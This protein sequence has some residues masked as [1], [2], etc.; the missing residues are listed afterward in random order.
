MT[1]IPSLQS[2]C[3]IPS[4]KDVYKFTKAH[5]YLQRNPAAAKR[6]ID[7][8][9]VFYRHLSFYRIR[10]ISQKNENSNDSSLDILSNPSTDENMLIT[11][12]NI[13]NVIQKW[14][15]VD[16]LDIQEENTSNDSNSFIVIFKTAISAHVMTKLIKFPELIQKNITLTIEAIDPIPEDAR[17][18]LVYIQG[19]GPD[20][21][22]DAIRNFF[23]DMSFILKIERYQK[24]NIY[25]HI[26]K[27]PSVRS[28][29][30]LTKQIN[31]GKFTRS[32]FAAFDG[33]SGYGPQSF[34]VSSHQYKSTIT[35][36]F[37]ITSDEKSSLKS[38]D[39]YSEVSK[40]GEI[41]TL[42]TRNN[43]NLC[44]FYIKMNSI[45]DSKLACGVMNNRI[46]DNVTLKAIFISTDY[47]NDLCTEFKHQN[48]T[49]QQD[50]QN[51]PPQFEY[52]MKEDVKFQQNQPFSQTLDVLQNEPS[53]EKQRIQIFKETEQQDQQVSENEKKI[54]EAPN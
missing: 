43:N 33:I 32:N 37:F 1:C 14:K 44:E 5:Q 53:I 49:I 48:Q 22:D 41:D 18:P 2:W 25:F 28:A 31:E 52:Q 8:D 39:V 23:R 11:A 35:Q 12:S 46:F 45:S 54:E 40:F 6:V 9:H 3:I 13:I 30:N 15:L 27:L 50:V 26:I 10:I 34:I 47:F 24:G 19:I 36:C 38:E 42:F 21:S 29:I 51:P 20:I 4:K 7:R 17:V 16:V